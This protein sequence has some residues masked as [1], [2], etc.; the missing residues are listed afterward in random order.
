[1]VWWENISE[2][3]NLDIDDEDNYLSEIINLF[4]RIY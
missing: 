4:D 2:E 3:E 1:M